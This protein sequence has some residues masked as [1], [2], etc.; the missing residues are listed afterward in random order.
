MTTKRRIAVISAMSVS[1]VLT[2]LIA[3]IAFN[4]F[5]RQHTVFDSQKWKT[6]ITPPRS[7]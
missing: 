3:V 2:L 1:L 6:D 5:R 4:V 7:S